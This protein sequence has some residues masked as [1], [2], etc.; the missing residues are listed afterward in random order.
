MPAFT[1]A[2]E[3][4][5]SLQLLNTFLVRLCPGHEGGTVSPSNWFFFERVQ[6]SVIFDFLVNIGVNVI[7]EF[8]SRLVIT[9]FLFEGA[10]SIKVKGK[11]K[12]Y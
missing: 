12:F 2:P 3:A 6:Y 8:Q 9:H 11:A 10:M 7:R 4:S 1:D 5:S